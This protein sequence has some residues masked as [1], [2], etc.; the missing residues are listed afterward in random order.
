MTLYEML[1][2]ELPFQGPDLLKLKEAGLFVPLS[3]KD[4][5]L[6]QSLDALMAAALEPDHAK[7][8]YRSIK[9]L[10]RLNS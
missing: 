6:P 4:P 5:S 1:T 9:F 7:R 10:Q 8:L 2:G 3:A